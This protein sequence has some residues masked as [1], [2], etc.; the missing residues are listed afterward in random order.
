MYEYLNMHQEKE[1][2]TEALWKQFGAKI[3]M[4]LLLHTCHKSVRLQHMAAL[5]GIALWV[6]FFFTLLTLS[7][8]TACHE[9]FSH[10]REPSSRGEI[11]GER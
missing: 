3:N 11:R 1:Y 7:S 2:H 8:F 6:I 10:C 5:S 4:C 9:V